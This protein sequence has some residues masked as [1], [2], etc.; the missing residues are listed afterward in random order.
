MH[1]KPPINLSILDFKYFLEH[2]KGRFADAI[3][4][5]ILDFKYNM[6]YFRYGRKQA[7]NLSILDFK[8]D[9][10]NNRTDNGTL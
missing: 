4:L 7:I 6:V 3:N 5:S 2:I 10:I 1:P 8:S 9:N